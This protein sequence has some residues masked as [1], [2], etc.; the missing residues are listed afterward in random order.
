MNLKKYIST[1]LGKVLRA[2]TRFPIMTLSA[3]LAL[4][5]IVIYYHF[6]T[7]F[8][9]PRRHWVYLAYECIVGI[10]MFFAFALFCEKYKVDTGKRVGLWLMGF[11][12]LG[13]HFLALPDWAINVDA[14]YFLRFFTFGVVCTL[15]VSFVLFYK[16]DDKIAFWQFNQY[17]VIQFFVATAFSLTLFVGLA[18]SLYAVEQ[19]FEFHIPEA[20]YVDLLAF[21]GI[22]VN[23]LFFSASIPKDFNWF[24]EPQSFRQPLRL[25]IQYVL[26]PL[27][28][29][30]YIILIAY[31]GKIVLAGVM[32]D[33]WVALPILIFSTL[34][35]LTY[36]LAYP[37]S[38][39]KE[40][41]SI[42]FY[43][44]YFFYF[45]LPLVTLLF[46]A[47]ITRVF[48]YSVTE[49][50]YL[51][52][53][54]GVWFLILTL[55][56]IIYKKTS[57]VLFPVSLF[58]LLFLGSV[59]PWG[60]Y[61]MSAS[62]QFRR[63]CK[64]LE[65]ENVIENKVVSVEKLQ[66]K[67]TDSIATEIGSINKFLFY[68]EQIDLIYPIL[69]ETHKKQIDSI[70]MS[71]NKI[72][73][74][75]E[76][77]KQTFSLPERERLQDYRT[78]HF[79]A[80]DVDSFSFDI[81]KYNQMQSYY[82]NNRNDGEE[83]FMQDGVLN[84]IRSTDTLQF[85]LYPY[86]DSLTAFYFSDHKTVQM[87]NDDLVSVPAGIENLKFEEEQERASIYFKELILKRN[88]DSLLHLESAS[89][90]LLK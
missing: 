76:F 37:L 29:I 56:T 55:Y 61:Q 62:G 15:L 20:Y 69:N 50:R 22:V 12:I 28:L 6:H 13:L 46:V 73:S 19:L 45:L 2:A 85:Q 4:V 38:Y 54:F 10:S 70:K 74:F 17:L 87:T 89:F 86:L 78:Y 48:T 32:P 57:L 40:H 79:F 21:F 33:G 66:E 30:Y 60:M 27:L 8:D 25:F 58:L 41:T 68:R 64:I 16:E 18:A 43:V 53:L 11:C 63:L 51:G 59:G 81:E 31:F 84:F 9:V 80:S 1:S 14:T 23:T 52:L 5:F 71:D 72:Y 34:G 26:L 82:L 47:L 3:L 36:F 7:N 88:A 24:R 49:Y 65:S 44:K 35:V 67:I 75:N 90:Y 83:I 39:E 42:R 77:L